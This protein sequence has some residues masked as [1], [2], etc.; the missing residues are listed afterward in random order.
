MCSSWSKG[1]SSPSNLLFPEKLLISLLTNQRIVASTI[2]V[3]HASDL[4][5]IYHQT[6]MS[7]EETVKSKVAF[8]K[9]S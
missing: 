8:E 3:D 5:Y 7:S 2:F 6:S 1:H 4:S 9:F